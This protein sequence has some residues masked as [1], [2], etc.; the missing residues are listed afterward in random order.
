MS[1]RESRRGIEGLLQSTPVPEPLRR[2]IVWAATSAWV[3]VAYLLSGVAIL[4][5]S[6]P[7]TPEGSLLLWPVMVGALALLAYTAIGYVSGALLPGRFTP[8]LVATG[9]FMGQFALAEG[10]LLAEVPDW[11]LALTPTALLESSA[12]AG[13]EAAVALAQSL[14]LVG[15]TG[16]VLAGLGMR[17]PAGRPR[18]YLLM[19]LAGAL[20]MVAGA[21]ALGEVVGQTPDGAKWMALCSG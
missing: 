3:I 20:L 2:I 17:G 10:A 5:L 19:L 1:G 18:G 16:V 15:L 11:L 8:P 13:V 7:S 6:L 21:V 12:W 14:F 4:A 9:I